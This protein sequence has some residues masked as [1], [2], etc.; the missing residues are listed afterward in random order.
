MR[1]FDSQGNMS[2]LDEEGNLRQ[3]IPNSDFFVFPINEAVLLPADDIFQVQLQPTDH[4]TFSLTFDFFNSENTFTDSSRFEEVPISINS[5][6][7]IF[8]DPGTTSQILEL[9]VEGD[10][11]VDH[12]IESGQPVPV[13]SYG[14]VLV[15]VIRTLEIRK[16]IRTELLSVVGAALAQLGRG[17]KIA[18]RNQFRALTLKVNAIMGVHLTTRQ[19]GI[20]LRLANKAINLLS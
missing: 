2:G 9:D 5:R 8:L 12:I 20:I 13:A 1:I 15:D 6:G 4:G 18:A 16:G 17:N 7:R 19:A 11:V 10:G 14:A 3:Q